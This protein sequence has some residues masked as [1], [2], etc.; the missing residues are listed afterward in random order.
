MS[1][2]NVFVERG[3]VAVLT[4]GIPATVRDYVEP[5]GWWREEER[6]GQVELRTGGRFGNDIKL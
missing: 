6:F 4:C 2:Y 5:V 1:V 3:N